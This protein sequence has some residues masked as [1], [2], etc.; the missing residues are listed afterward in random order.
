MFIILICWNKTILALMGDY[1]YTVHKGNY[2]EN[3]KL[4]PKKSPKSDELIIEYHKKLR[5]DIQV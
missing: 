1:D 2:V 4:I 5:W 3:Q